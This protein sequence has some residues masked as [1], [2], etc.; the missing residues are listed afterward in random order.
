MQSGNYYCDFTNFLNT[1]RHNGKRP[2]MC[3]YICQNNTCTISGGSYKK[4]VHSLQLER[5]EELSEDRREDS[6]QYIPLIMIEILIEYILFIIKEYLN[7]LK[8]KNSVFPQL[9]H[10]RD[11]TQEGGSK[12]WLLLLQVHNPRQDDHINLVFNED[13]MVEC[14]MQTEGGSHGVPRS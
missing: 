13:A 2:E 12:L 7:N 4:P 5:E 14:G 8:Q 11:A 10:L 1:Q 6:F 3:L 9:R